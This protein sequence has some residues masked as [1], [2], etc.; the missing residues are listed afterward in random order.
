VPYPQQMKEAKEQFERVKRWLGK[1]ENI[2]KEKQLSLGK[3]LN[4]KENIDFIYAFFQ[5]CYHLRDWIVTSKIINET[6]VDNFIQSNIDMQ[7]CR[8]ICNGSKHLIITKPS[9][10]YDIHKTLHSSIFSSSINNQKPEI[11]LYYFIT[12]NGVALN[13]LE[14][15]RNCVRLWE[16]FLKM[17]SIIEL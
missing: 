10:S 5:N 6:I 9:V 2:F 17:N 3:L 8:D 4:D 1:V 15:A 16:R 7:I 12:F 14:V 11:E 13:S